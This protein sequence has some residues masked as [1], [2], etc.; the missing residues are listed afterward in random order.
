MKHGLG[1]SGSDDEKAPSDHN[2]AAQ[3]IHA[4]GLDS[5][6]DDGN[7]GSLGQHHPDTTQP[8][9]PGD[10][11]NDFKALGLEGTDDEFND[12]HG[13]EEEEDKQPS[14]GP[15]QFKPDR[16]YGPPQVLFFL[17]SIKEHI[18]VFI[19]GAASESGHSGVEVATS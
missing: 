3:A 16:M 1:L 14:P 4:A 9:G 11:D 10:E 13:L 18:W 8:E 6:D 17:A 12:Q 19:P 15:K 2:T 5:D 7:N